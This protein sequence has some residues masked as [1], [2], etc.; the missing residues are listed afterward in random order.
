MTRI[1]IP[2]ALFGLLLG[3]AW[4]VGLPQSPA[5]VPESGA[6]EVYKWV[7]DRGVVHFTDSPENIPPKYRQKTDIRRL[8]STPITQGAP[9][10]PAPPAVSPGAAAGQP[11]GRPT[12]GVPPTTPPGAPPGTTTASSSAQAVEAARGEVRALQD[13]LAQKRKYVELFE[14]S[15]RF[16][17]IYSQDEIKKYNDY[18]SEIPRDEGRLKELQA[19]LEELE[20][21][22]EAAA[23]R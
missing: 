4:M 10:A 19:R 23:R 21:E 13:A 20:Q 7:D 9:S 3:A 6:A 12:P 11:P 5:H 16:G 14:R 1:G 18:V 2:Q 22:A 8:P 17:V 15:R